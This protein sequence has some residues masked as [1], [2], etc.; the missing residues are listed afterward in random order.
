MNND[1]IVI[2]MPLYLQLYKYNERN[3]DIGTI[4]H[5]IQSHR[6][7]RTLIIHIAGVL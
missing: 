2:T 1:I 6:M 3:F 5:I 4:A 7:R